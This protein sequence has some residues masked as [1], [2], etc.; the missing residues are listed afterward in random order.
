MDNNVLS[1]TNS[2]EF[3]DK[4]KGK[5]IDKYV[6]ERKLIVQKLYD[7]LDLKTDNNVK[8]FYPADLTDEKQNE[9]INLKEEIKQYF[10]VGTWICYKNT[11]KLDKIHMSIIRNILKHEKINYTITK[12]MIGGVHKIKYVI[13]DN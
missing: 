6:E 10:K 2:T 3:V 12:K 9:I 5:K 1:D 8:Y 13:S 11:I 7:I 4:R